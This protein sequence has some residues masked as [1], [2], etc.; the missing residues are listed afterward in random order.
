[1]EN[2]RGVPGQLCP[3]YSSHSARG[4]CVVWRGLDGGDKEGDGFDSGGENCGPQRALAF[5]QVTRRLSMRPP[6]SPG[7][8]GLTATKGIT[9]I[10]AL[11]A[12]K[13]DGKTT[14]PP[15]LSS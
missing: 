9:H 4:L 5:P 2:C 7:Q 14:L 3:S 12:V 6:Q 1:M 11:R 10:D 8:L 15:A 13:V